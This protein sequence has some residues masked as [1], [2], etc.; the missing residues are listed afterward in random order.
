MH[1][2]LPENNVFSLF[3]A[4]DFVPGPGNYSTRLE[5]LKGEYLLSNFM[6]NKT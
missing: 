6:S 1:N 5:K 4:N 2:D 3:I